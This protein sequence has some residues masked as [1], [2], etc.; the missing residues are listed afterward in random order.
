MGAAYPQVLVSQ[1]TYFQLQVGYIKFLKISGVNAI[2]RQN[3][4]LSSGLEALRPS[5]IV[6]TTVN[7]P[8]SRGGSAQ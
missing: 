4:T 7:L 5:G 2:A 1:R 3:Y 8:N 6:A